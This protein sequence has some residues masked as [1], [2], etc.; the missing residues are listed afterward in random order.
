MNQKEREQIRTEALENTPPKRIDPQE[1]H[2]EGYLQE[3]NR[4]FFHPLGLALE[5]ITDEEG[6]TVDIGGIWDYRDEP[7]GMRYDIANRSEEE[8]KEMKDKA[9]HIQNQMIDKAKTR[10]N[11]FGGVV[12]EPIPGMQVGQ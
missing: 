12:V 8:Q 2:D 10:V 6:N 4:M 3:A 1:F 7:E 5:V 11:M 9:L